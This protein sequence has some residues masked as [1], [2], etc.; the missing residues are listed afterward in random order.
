MATTIAKSL[1]QRKTLAQKLAE[2]NSRIVR[3]AVINEDIE[4]DFSVEKIL[5]EMSVI[6]EQL[7]AVKTNVARASV[8]IMI[9]V[10]IPNGEVKIPLYEAVLLRDDMKSR[11]ALVKQ[12]IDMPTTSERGWREEK[13]T[14][15]KKRTFNFES[16]V[17]E[18][19]N[20]QELI[21]EVD[22][23]IQF[24]DNTKEI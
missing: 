4:P 7:R 22:A 3:S 21:D 9:D 13:D 18:M 19:E 11:L 8:H 1:R 10:S 23:R 14:P 5:N 16:A 17:K 2:C 12:L 20:L 24:A 6:Q 15:K